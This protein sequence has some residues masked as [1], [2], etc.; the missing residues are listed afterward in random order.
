M[1]LSICHCD[2]EVSWAPLASLIPNLDIHQGNLLLVPIL[3]EFESSTSLGWKE[4][5]DKKLF[6][7]GLMAAS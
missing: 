3:F 7:I 2:M 5:V 6:D 1:R 4:W